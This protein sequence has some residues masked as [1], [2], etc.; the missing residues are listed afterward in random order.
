MSLSPTVE[1][2]A[3]VGDA[4]DAMVLTRA[5]PLLGTLVQISVAGLPLAEGNRALDRAF[6]AIDRVHVLMSFQSPDS[7]LSYLNGRAL[8]A[9]VTVS[10]STWEVLQTAQ[11]LARLSGGLFDIT[12]A[13]TLQALGYLP[14]HVGMAFAAEGTSWRDLQLLPG[15]RVRFSRPLCIDLSGIAKGY[16]VDGAVQ[17]LCDSGAAGGCVN[18]GGDLRCFGPLPQVVDV[19]HPAQPGVTLPLLQLHDRA[20]ATSAHYYAR[21]SLE[22]RTVTPL[23]HP[24]RGEVLTQDISVTV[25][26]SSCMLADALTKVVH[27]DAQRALPVLAK[28]GADALILQVDPFSGDCM[29]RDTRAQPAGS[30]ESTD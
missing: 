22:G 4:A 11:R 9:P 10:P 15:Q 5:R 28:L 16:A 8:Q 7:E 26:A 24:G 12:V 2:Q 6:A 21:R 17:V 29:V 25:L 3:R 14:G 20:A 30:R 1:A 13:S 18:A 19:R 23:I 27:A